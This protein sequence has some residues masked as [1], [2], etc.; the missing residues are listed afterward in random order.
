M[1]N[2]VQAVAEN[3]P[4]TFY[5]DNTCI[6]CGTCRHVAPAT[7]AEAADYSFVHQQPQNP[8]AVQSACHALLACPTGS[9]GTLET[10]PEIKHARQDFPLFVTDNVFYNGYT[11]PKSYGASSYL[12]THPQG[13]WLVDSPKFLPAVV[14]SLEAKGGI[15]YIFLTHSDDVADAERFAAHFGATRIIPQQELWSQP[16]AEWILDGTDP[17]TLAAGFVAIPVPGHTL[18]SCC[19]L[20]ENRVLFSGDHCW[21]SPQT[22]QLE[23]PQHI[24]RNKSLMAKSHQIL[25]A[26]HTIDWVLPGH[27]MGVCLLDTKMTL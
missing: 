6:D 21:W 5:V 12:V 15:A 1:A 25:L 10:L 7:F 14:Q 2:P 16:E 26:N 23:T 17:I 4:G 11:S 27:G 8:Q 19:L 3:L 20:Y 22:Q 9:I 24:Y 13:N 18:G